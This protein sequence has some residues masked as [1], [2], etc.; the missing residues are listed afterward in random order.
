MTDSIEKGPPGSEKVSPR[1]FIRLIRD[2]QHDHTARRQG[3]GPGSLA[4]AQERLRRWQSERLA[5]TY[6][7]LLADPQYRLAGLFF[8]TDIY[9]AKDFS[10]RDYDAEQLHAVLARFLPDVALRLLADTIHLNR[11]SSRLDDQLIGV[12]DPE[13]PITPDSY[14]RGYLD[15]D[16]Y[17][18]RR[19]QIELLARTLREAALAARSAVFVISLK[20]ARLPAQ[21]AGW[22]ELYDFLLRGYQACRPMRNVSYFVDTI[23]Q[24]ELSILDNIF[25][26][27]LNPF[28]AV[29]D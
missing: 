8:L 1:E 18:E 25:A 22:D 27:M 15:C 5:A 14:A 29:S 26:G 19:E 2:L 16:N 28:Q 13:G 20:L 4:P 21:R 6:A 12:M 23:H 7:D 3:I 11:M 24:R 9:A 17:A 10:Q